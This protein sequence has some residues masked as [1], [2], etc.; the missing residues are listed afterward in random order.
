MSMTAQQ[1][2]AFQ[3]MGGFTPAQ[4]TTLLTGLVLTI[5]LVFAAWAIG[6]AY[7]GWARGQLPQGR[8]AEISIKVAL[9]YLLLTLL[10]L[11]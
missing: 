10:L 11:K 6:S 5:A 9:I 7:R 1:L 8:L 2:T 3:T 4:S